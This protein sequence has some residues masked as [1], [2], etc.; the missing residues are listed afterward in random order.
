MK[1][2]EYAYLENEIDTKKLSELVKQ[3]L[4]DLRLN[5]I[6]KPKLVRQTARCWSVDNLQAFYFNNT[7][8]KY[9]L[10]LIKQNS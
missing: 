10:E 3:D 7:L 5:K 4:E 2:Q 1:N 9:Y 6:E 8:E